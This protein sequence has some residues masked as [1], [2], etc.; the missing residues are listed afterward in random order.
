VLHEDLYDLMRVRGFFGGYYLDALAGVDIAVWDLAAKRAR[1]LALDRRA[2]ASARR[3]FRPMSP[4]CRSRR[5]PSACE[6]AQEWI[7]RGFR[8]IKF[9]AAVADDGDRARDGGAA[10]GGRPEG[11]IMVRPALEVRRRPRRSG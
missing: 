11:V 6:L 9:A 2:A 7:A 10:R 1:P 4:G 3:G 5:W 8:A